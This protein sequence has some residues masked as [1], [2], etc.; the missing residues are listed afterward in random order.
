MT[1]INKHEF[2]KAIKK[3]RQDNDLT[4]NELA[5]KLGIAITT[6]ARWE[7]ELNVPKQQILIR[8]LKELGINW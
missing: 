7:L 1:T 8:Q 2:A 5:Q 6:V 3:Y 4:Q